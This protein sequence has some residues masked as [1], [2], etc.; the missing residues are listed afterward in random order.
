VHGISFRGRKPLWRRVC[1]DTRLAFSAF[2]QQKY[3]LPW[4]TPQTL[5]LADP[6]PFYAMQYISDFHVKASVGALHN[7]KFHYRIPHSSSS[8]S[9]PV[10]QNHDSIF[11]TSLRYFGNHTLKSE[12]SPH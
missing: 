11:V 7:R 1:G 8:D 9:E 10:S 3:L 2:E 5:G 6:F 4:T 12:L